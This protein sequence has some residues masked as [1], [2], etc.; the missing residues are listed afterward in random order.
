LSQYG[1]EESSHA[2]TKCPPSAPDRTLELATHRRDCPAC[3]RP[4]SVANKPRRTV[5]T[6]QG[7]V[8]LRLQV[9]SALT[10]DGRPPLDAS[11]LKLHGRLTAVAEG[12]DRV[13][14]KRGCRRS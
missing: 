1:F 11:G 4:L 7:L 2:A 3:G 8:R 5:S 6:P 14:G 13:G 12:L 9:R 10:D